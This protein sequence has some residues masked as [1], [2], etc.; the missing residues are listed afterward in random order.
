MDST[1]EAL[2]AAV[3][4]I[5]Y[6]RSSAIQLTKVFER[7][8]SYSTVRIHYGRKTERPEKTHKSRQ[9]SFHTSVKSLN[10]IIEIVNSRKAS[11]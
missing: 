7:L 10:R 3:V 2:N 8:D 11:F 6:K 5:T 9:N 4:I 1:K